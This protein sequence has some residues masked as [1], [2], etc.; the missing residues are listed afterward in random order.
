MPQVQAAAPYVFPVLSI[1]SLATRRS[2]LVTVFLLAYLLRDLLLLISSV[3]ED[4]RLVNPT[5]FKFCCG[6]RVV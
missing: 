1:V 4:L 3:T 5:Q 2:D 6:I